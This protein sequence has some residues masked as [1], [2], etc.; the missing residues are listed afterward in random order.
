MLHIIIFLNYCVNNA[1]LNALEGCVIQMNFRGI[2]CEN[3]SHGDYC[4]ADTLQTCN[5][6]AVKINRSESF[7]IKMKFLLNVSQCYHIYSHKQ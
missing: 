2:I 6:V 4:K 5:V 1:I 3:N 7:I